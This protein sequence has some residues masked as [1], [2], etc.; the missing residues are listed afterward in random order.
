MPLIPLGT[1]SIGESRQLWHF[2][3]LSSSG[4]PETWSHQTEDDF[5]HTFEFF[6][7][8]LNQSLDQ[9]WHPVFHEAFAFFAPRCMAD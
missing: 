4:L 5:G 8:P 1:Y 3:K 2:F 9:N 7:H 6:W